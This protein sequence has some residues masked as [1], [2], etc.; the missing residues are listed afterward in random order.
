MMGPRAQLFRFLSRLVAGAAVLLW[1]MI[2]FAEPVKVTG[3]ASLT[4]PLSDSAAAFRVAGVDLRVEAAGGNPAASATVGQRRADVAMM[5]RG[6][7]PQEKSKYPTRRF[8][9]VVI[10]AQAFTPAVARNVWESGVKAI[11]KEQMQ[12]IYEGKIKKWSELG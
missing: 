3:P 4:K 1:S 11:S 2:A 7:T 6:L 12:K 10:A 5:S 9:E 8:F